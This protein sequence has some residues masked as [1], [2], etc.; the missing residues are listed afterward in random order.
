MIALLVF[1]TVARAWNACDWSFDLPSRL[2]EYV[3]CRFVNEAF[4][5]DGKMVCELVLSRTQ[6]K[7]DLHGPLVTVAI[8][9]AGP[10]KVVAV[11]EVTLHGGP[12]VRLPLRDAFP[13]VKP[14]PLLE[15]DNGWRSNT[16][17]QCDATV[18]ALTCG[19]LKTHHGFAISTK[20]QIDTF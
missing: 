10:A 18:N 1:P 15:P 2:A 9:E 19:S 17:L 12:G 7:Q 20:G 14:K 11:L 3:I 6:A 16:G 5:S 8:K 4:G 13:V